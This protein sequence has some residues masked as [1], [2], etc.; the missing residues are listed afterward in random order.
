MITKDEKIRIIT[1]VEIEE[2]FDTLR[3]E[4]E[5]AEKQEKELENT[6]TV[7]NDFLERR[8]NYEKEKR[9][10]AYKSIY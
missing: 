4:K 5:L 9:Q 6:L 1:E 2:M 7:L 8:K 10:M 3:F